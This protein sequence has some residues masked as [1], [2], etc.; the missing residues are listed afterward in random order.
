MRS[1][2]NI[3]FHVGYLSYISLAVPYISLSIQQC[4][5]CIINVLQH[6]TCFEILM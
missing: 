4:I 2:I 1:S 5:I 6:L 3:L